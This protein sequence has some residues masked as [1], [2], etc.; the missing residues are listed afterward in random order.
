MQGIITPELFWLVVTIVMTALL[1]IPI[2]INRIVEVG[3]W[4]TLKP[5]RLQSKA[6]WAERLMR[7]HANAVENLV[8]FVP[9]AL[10]IN[11]TGISTTVTATACMIYFFARLIH[12]LAYV[13]AIPVIRTL[14]FVA[15][16]LCQ[17]TLAITLLRLTQSTL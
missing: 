10:I 16:F 7:A 17:M 6:A 1:W 15:G 14:A 4:S 9:L 3:V 11:K 13:A 12:V 8:I 5:P 2:I